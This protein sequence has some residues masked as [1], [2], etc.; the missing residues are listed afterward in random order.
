MRAYF[1]NLSVLWKLGYKLNPKGLYLM[2]FEPIHELN[3]SLI[4]TC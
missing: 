1:T 3:L 4:A 2:R